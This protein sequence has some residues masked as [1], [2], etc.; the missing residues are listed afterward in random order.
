V[1]EQRA[2][3]ACVAAGVAWL[4][5]VVASALDLSGSAYHAAMGVALAWLVFA[6]WFFGRLWSARGPRARAGF[7]LVLGGLVLATV[8]APF[9][10]SGLFVL[11]VFAMLVGGPT[12]AVGLRRSG[13]PFWALALV[14]LIGFGVLCGDLFTDAPLP[15]A[16]GGIGFFAAGWIAL[17]LLLRRRPYAFSSTPT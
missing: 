11:G 4:A 13:L 5:L 2:A 14:C 1:A 6:W 7:W 3:V 16:L 12:A 17:G 15:A 8:G 10:A 9:E